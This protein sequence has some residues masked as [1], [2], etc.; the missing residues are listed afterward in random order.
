M[1]ARAARTLEASIPI[2]ELEIVSNVDSTCIVFTR[3]RIIFRH[4]IA[5][6]PGALCA[7]YINNTKNDRPY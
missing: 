7:V 4:N 1:F 5:E 3:L 6:Q 2:S